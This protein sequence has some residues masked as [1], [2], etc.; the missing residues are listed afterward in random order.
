M[1]ELLNNIYIK[2]MKEI[3]YPEFK[4]WYICWN[5]N[6]EK[7]MVQGFVKPNQVMTTY[8]DILDTYTN[9]SDWK[10]VLLADGMTEDEINKI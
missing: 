4:T 6:R 5:E 3:K 9:E 7:R 2:Q 10:E 1:V 8:W